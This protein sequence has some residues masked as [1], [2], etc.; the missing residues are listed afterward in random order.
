MV[1]SVVIMC[2]CAHFL[3]GYHVGRNARILLDQANRA[4]QVGHLNKTVEF[5]R[6]YLVHKP[7]DTDALARLGLALG[8]PEASSRAQLEARSVLEKVLLGEPGRRDLRRRLASLLMAQGQTADAK[9]HLQILLQIS[10]NDGELEEQMGR[11]E[12]ADGDAKAAEQWYTNAI[13]D[14]PTRVESYSLLADL[15]RQ[16]DGPPERADELMERMVRSNPQSFEAYVA[17]ARYRSKWGQGH[18]EADLAQARKLAPD[19]PS[20]L[21]AS[22]VCAKKR[23]NHNKAEFDEGRKY[24]ERGVA[25]Y[26]RL[27]RL[28]QAL[29]ALHLRSGRPDEAVICLRAGLRALPDSAGRNELRW[30]LADVL[31][32]RESVE[33]ARA[34][35]VHLRAEGHPP[36][37]LDYLEA[38][39]RIKNKEWLE[40]GT[41][42]EHL[43]LP[44]IQS[45]ELV[46]QIDLL[47]GQC[48]GQLGKSDLQLEVYQRAVA[49]DRSC[50]LAKEQL[51][52]TL[53]VLGRNDEALEAYRALAADNPAARIVVARLLIL[54]NLRLAPELRDWREVNEQVNKAA[55]AVPEAVEVP[56]VR[57]EVLWAQG[58]PAE[59]Q[60]VLDQARQHRPEQIS[61]WLALADCE[62]REGMHAAASALLAE[63]HKK[64]GDHVSLRMARLRA[65]T[66]VPPSPKGRQVVAELGKDIEKFSDTEQVTLLIGLAEACQ[67][68]GD[69]GRAEEFWNGLARREPWNLRLRLSLFNLAVETG[70]TSAIQRMVADM[71][72]IEGETGTL[73]RYG[74]AALQLLLA[75]AGDRRG[76]ETARWRLSEA[77]NRRPGWFYVPLLEAQIDDFQGKADFALMNYRRALA[78]GARQPAVVLRLVQLL[79]ERQ[80]YVEADEVLQQ[81]QKDVL[82][83]A[84]LE[85]LA[86]E[87]ALHNQDTERALA[88]ARS[89]VSRQPED[90]RNHLWLGFSLWESGRQPEAEAALRHAIKAGG[91]APEAWVA[92]INYLVRTNQKEKVKTALQEAQARLRVGEGRLA[93]AQ[94]YE[95]AVDY[96][97]AKEHYQATLGAKPDDPLVLRNVAAFYLRA[98][99]LLQAEP[100]LRKLL[101]LANRASAADTAWARR[102]LAVALASD[103]SYKNFREALTL[104]DR[105]SKDPGTS[106][107]D[108]RAKAALLAARPDRQGEALRL[109]Q[110]LGS[111][112]TAADR[113]LEARL[114]EAKAD[115]RMAGEKLITLLADDPDNPLYLAHYAK[116]LLARSEIDGAQLCIARLQKV[117]PAAYRTAEIK[118]RLL[119]MENMDV[120]AVT[121]LKKFVEGKDIEYLSLVAGLLEELGQTHIAEETYRHYVS[122]SKRPESI[123]MLAGYLARRNRARE[124]LDLCERAWQTCPAETAALASVIVLFA[125]EVD[126]QQSERVA[127]WLEG[128]IKSNPRTTSLFFDLANVRSLQGHFQQAESLY[129]RVLEQDESHIDALNNLAFLLATQ[130]GR[131]AEA[132]DLINRAIN[133]GGPAADRQDT[134]AV[135]H[136]ARGHADLAINELEAAVATGPTASRYFHLARAHLL[137][138]DRTGALAA[139][140]KGKMLGLKPRS[141]HPLERAAYAEL[142]DELEPK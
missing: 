103:G 93:L 43:R 69:T 20:V 19:Q 48:Y 78:L 71:R 21:L 38:R 86:A 95:L 129:R 83:P 41:I 68:L 116:S 133:I 124:A 128:A 61:L 87:I 113:F 36:A 45:S 99:E 142:L 58:K 6:R 32:E 17:R 74:E 121:L 88:L 35:M 13:K 47:L 135:V 89:A 49:G 137:Q 109:L 64:L 131:A 96:D 101:A 56:I 125:A 141:V 9:K 25:L 12:E 79:Y 104:L 59:A 42:L 16:G 77:A 97:Q 84:E 54:R 34:E 106:A 102:N 82:L 1:T 112:R 26:P 40:A 39:I 107:D 18:V 44:R 37:S 7:G 72:R 120:E 53:L 24:L 8:H 114:Y 126:E 67:R 92:L 100:I 90:Y 30:N 117:Q 127:N 65:I 140:Q 139:L 10:P 29:A 62:E 132:L 91:D 123:L 52:A 73:W 57:A 63:A 119:H 130:G 85:R 60:K 28:H 80:R 4:E 138:R 5:L 108:Q 27:A 3:H 110:E 51:A 22:G 81:V 23:G 15:Y 111:Q 33:E 75:R 105:N 11:C 98:G 46:T 70:N 134:L 94:C 50:R 55:A 76:L 31:I 136:M 122:G 115:W 14:V 66:L 2:G 118:A